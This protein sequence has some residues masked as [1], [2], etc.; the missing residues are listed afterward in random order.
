MSDRASG[1]DRLIRAMADDP[2]PYADFVLVLLAAK[3]TG[4]PW[5]AAWKS[6]IQNMQPP[7]NP[8]PDVAERLIADRAMLVECV[9]AFRAFYEDEPVN[10]DLRQRAEELA[11]ARFSDLVVVD[12][13]EELPVAA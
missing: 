8:P 11:A 3:R 7:R 1:E 6:A 2:S 9:P 4:A 5:R 13:D 12:V 10:H